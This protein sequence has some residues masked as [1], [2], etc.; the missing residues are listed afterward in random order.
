MQFD[1]SSINEPI[2][3]PCNDSKPAHGCPKTL[4]VNLATNKD[5]FKILVFGLVI[6]SNVGLL[7]FS[8]TV[9]AQVF[10]GP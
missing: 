6:I 2:P 5:G 3:D 9:H 7:S 8:K 4:A 10:P 1:E